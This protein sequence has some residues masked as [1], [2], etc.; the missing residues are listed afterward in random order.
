MGCSPTNS[1]TA[2]TSTNVARTIRRTEGRYPR[3]RAVNLPFA[4][5]AARVRARHAFQACERQ[6]REAVRSAEEEGHVEGACGP[7]RK[8]TRRLEARRQEVGHGRQR[9]AGWYH[10]AAQG[11]RTQGREGRGQEEQEAVIRDV[12][13]LHAVE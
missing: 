1:A 6:E 4:Q 5:V 7:D 9:Q 2:T 12:L 13:R 10:R 8:L 11:G 3:P